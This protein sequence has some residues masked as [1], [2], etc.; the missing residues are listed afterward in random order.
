MIYYTKISIT[1]NAIIIA[2]FLAMSIALLVHNSLIGWL[3]IPLVIY[4]IYDIY[5]NHKRSALKE[6]Q[7]I[8]NAKGI[9][10]Q[11]IG[12]YEWKDIWNDQVIARKIGKATINFLEYSHPRGK[13][14]LQLMSYDI[15]KK[16]LIHLLH[17]YR[18]RSEKRSASAF[19]S[20]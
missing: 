7:I 17:T 15:K 11:K 2:G 5:K 12:F 3:G 14:K 9:A 16:T 19:K 18:A 1:I 6:P 10:V 4:M 8:L 20:N 13:V